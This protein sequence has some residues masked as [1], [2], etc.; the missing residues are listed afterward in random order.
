VPPGRSV[1]KIA[2][3]VAA[4]GIVLASGTAS[5]AT[6][7]ERVKSAYIYKLASFVRWPDDPRRS[8]FRLCVAGNNEVTLALRSLASGERVLGLP[9]TVATIDPKAPAQARNCQVVYVGRG[10][11]GA[12]AILAAVDGLPI[13]TVGDRNAGSEGGV[14]DFVVR[15]GKVRFIID[16]G[17]ARKQRLELSSKLLDIAVEVSG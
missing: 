3:A 17:F 15:D 12:R 16:R 9:V 7:E 1:I 5:A 6:P 4:L 14:I 11:E 10:R 2:C 8:E 13:L